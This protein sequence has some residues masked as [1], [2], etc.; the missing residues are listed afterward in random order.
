MVQKINKDRPCNS[1]RLHEAGG[2]SKMGVLDNHQYPYMILDGETWLFRRISDYY[3]T[4]SDRAI[5]VRARHD[6]C[7]SDCSCLTSALKDPN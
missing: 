6:G 4:R 1:H 2:V 3:G 7:G 5:L